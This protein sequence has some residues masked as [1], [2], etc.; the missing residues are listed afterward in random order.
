ME[1][2]TLYN[3][4]RAVPKEAQKTIQGGNLNGKT[5]IN[6]MWRIKTLTE[7]F[8][9]VGFGWYTKIIEHWDD[10]QVIGGNTERVAWVRLELYV[11]QGGEWSVGIEGI[12]GSKYAG[13]GRGS[14]LND[15]AFKM[16]ETDAISVACKKLGIGADIYWDKDNTKYTQGGQ[17]AQTRSGIVPITR[18]PE[19]ADW[20]N[21]LVQQAANGFSREACE[22]ETIKRGRTIP[23]DLWEQIIVNL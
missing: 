20:V 23:V 10:T 11:K 12:G 22:K 3:R 13:K 1:N 7:T 18:K 4:F 19:D 2:L 6:P 9:P 17:Q 21:W 16:A 8:G 5:D 15:E 14:E